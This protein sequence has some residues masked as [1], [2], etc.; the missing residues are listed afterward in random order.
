MFGMTASVTSND[1]AGR[2]YNKWKNEHVLA[3]L[4]RTT[5]LESMWN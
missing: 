4:Y 1:Q 3:L 5:W 2:Q